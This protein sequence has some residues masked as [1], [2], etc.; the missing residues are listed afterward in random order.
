MKKFY[1]SVAALVGLAA[2]ANCQ[3]FPAEIDV[4][5]WDTTDWKPSAVVLGQSPLS[6][7]VLLV[8]GNTMVESFDYSGNEVSTPC[9]QWN[10]FIGFTADEN[11][12]DLGW[13]SVNHEMIETNDNIGDGGGMTVFKVR[14]NA[15]S[16]TL[17]VVTQ[18]LTDGRSGEFFNV[19]FINTVGET[20]MNCGGITSTVDGRIW[21]AEE[22]FAGSMSSISS[23][24]RD[25]ADWVID[26]DIDGNFDGQTVRKY[27][28]FNY[29]VEIDPREAVAIR[30]QYNWGRQGFEGGVVMADNKTVF[31]G[32]DATP[33]AWLKFVADNAGDFTS[34]QLYF[35]KHDAT[36]SKWISVDNDD[37]AVALH[38][39]DYTFSNGATMFNRVEWVTYSETTGKVYFTETGRDNPGSRWADEYAN[40]AVFAPEHV[41]RATAQGTT[42]DNSAYADY[43]GRVWEFD[44]STDE[45][46]VFVSGGPEYLNQNEVSIDDYP[47]KHLSN[48]D[49]LNMF[50]TTIDG[51]DHEY[52]LICEDLNGQSHGRVPEGTNNSTCELWMLDMNTENPTVDDLFRLAVV[53]AGAEVTGATGISDGKSILFNVQHPSSSNPYPYNNSLT[54]A[55][56]GIQDAVSQGLLWATGVQEEAASKG[57]FKIY[58]NP[59]SREIRFT[60]TTDVAI[61]DVTGKRVK[62]ARQVQYVNV[63]SLPAGIYYV[64]NANGETTPLVIK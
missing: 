58:P 15:T 7:Q 13:V 24:V 62:V 61:Y 46:D 1:L 38:L 45:L 49:G 51:V 16:D 60:E 37:I 9:K 32:V 54:I 20:G 31:L 50:K 55:V 2:S 6:S 42:P 8:G 21:T 26:T 39:D 25:T 11:S 40:G 14:R 43:Y 17:E 22:W 4:T 30:K 29:M 53:P 36:G 48:P 28:N 35:Y 34:G 47:A 19:D 52:M 3:S 18:T 57:A 64:R 12:S 5:S 27:E 44:P 56:N 59:A 33:A 63:E 23:G 41:A 10:D